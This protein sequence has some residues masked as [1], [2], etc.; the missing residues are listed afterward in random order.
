MVAD[1]T[2]AVCVRAWTLLQGAT[3]ANFQICV[4][5][6]FQRTHEGDNASVCRGANVHVLIRPGGA[7]YSYMCPQCCSPG[8]QRAGAES[9]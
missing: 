1:A 3:L 4:S 7:S 9:R 2:A 5:V 6:V 8:I